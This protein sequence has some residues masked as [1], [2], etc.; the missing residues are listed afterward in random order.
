MK[1][2]ACDGRGTIQ[3]FPCDGFGRIFRVLPGA[4]CLVE[5]PCP[6]CGGEGLVPCLLCRGRGEAGLDKRTLFRRIQAKFRAQR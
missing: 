2:P 3:C 6:H 4:M 1:C 5:E